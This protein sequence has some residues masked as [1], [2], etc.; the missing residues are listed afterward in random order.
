MLDATYKPLTYWPKPPTAERRFS[1]FK[2]LWRKVLDLLEYELRRLDARDVVIFL[3]V[4]SADIRN[5]GALRSGAVVR[6]P[7]VLLSFTGRHGP[8][9]YPCDAF[10]TW[11]DNL[12][13]VARSLEALR[14]ID[15]YGVSCSGEQYRGF[16][17]LPSPQTAREE[18]AR[19]LARHGDGDAARILTDGEYRTAVWR[20]ASKATHPDQGGDAARFSQVQ[21][22]RRLLEAAA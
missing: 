12:H 8:Q 2:M 9:F 11:Q 19:I 6:S 16:T 17:P 1:P 7:R 4:T 13:A 5:D 21:E 18:A 14:M 10:A 15:R 3:D 20:A 22:A